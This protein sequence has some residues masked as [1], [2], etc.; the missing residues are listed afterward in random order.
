MSVAILI[1]TPDATKKALELCRKAPAM[2]PALPAQ[3]MTLA[4]AALQKAVS[5]SER[6]QLIAAFHRLALKVLS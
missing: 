3:A 5:L 1:T 4:I 2:E 6:A